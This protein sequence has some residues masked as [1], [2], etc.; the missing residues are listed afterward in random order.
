MVEITHNGNGWHV[1]AHFVIESYYFPQR[2]IHKLWSSIVG[3]GTVFIKD[4]PVGAI[5]NYLTKYLTKGMV[6]GKRNEALNRALKG[7]RL[8]QP[9]GNWHSQMG[10]FTPIKRKCP[11]CGD[12]RYTLYEH[13]L[14]IG[15]NYRGEPVYYPRDS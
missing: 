4:M 1:H 11:V 10:S 6:E 8:F 12:V 13:E 14:S 3:E 7:K 15:V 2:Q 9:F 5:V